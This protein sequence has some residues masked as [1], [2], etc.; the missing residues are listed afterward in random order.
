MLFSEMF[1]D[2]EMYLKDMQMYLRGTH[3]GNQPMQ[4]SGDICEQCGEFCT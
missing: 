1:T 2:L 3:M 4:G